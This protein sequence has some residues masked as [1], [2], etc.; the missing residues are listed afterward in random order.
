M[1][2]TVNVTWRA[3]G[4]RPMIGYEA[5]TSTTFEI[6]TD[7]PELALCEEIYKQT[8]LYN[9]EMWDLMQPLPEGRTHTAISVIFDRGDYVTIDG[10][11]YEVA[12]M[13][14]RKVN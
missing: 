6:E 4:D 8:N 13:G 9:G 7:L 1:K 11:T 2:R 14:F 12:S 5:E 10:T 3:F